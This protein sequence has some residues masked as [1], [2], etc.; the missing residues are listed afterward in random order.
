VRQLIIE[1]GALGLPVWE[2]GR[3]GKIRLGIG[4]V[5]NRL[6]AR[7]DIPAPATM[8]AALK[9]AEDNAADLR[10]LLAAEFGQAP[11]RPQ[12]WYQRNPL[13]RST[14]QH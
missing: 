1:W 14:Q 11:K 6:Q 4:Q 7:F 5:L 8:Y 3:R 9:F 12:V 13:W 2:V 10:A